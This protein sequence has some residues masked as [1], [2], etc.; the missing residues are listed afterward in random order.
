MTD[1]IAALE[2]LL[3]CLIY[4]AVDAKAGF[5]NVVV[6]EELQTYLGIIT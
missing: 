1:C 2:A 4:C 6:P 5:L 3:G